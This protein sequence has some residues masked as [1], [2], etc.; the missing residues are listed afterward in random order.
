MSGLQKCRRRNILE[1]LSA[2]RRRV[3]QLESK[4]IESIIHYWILMEENK[5][6]QHQ[7]EARNLAVAS[8]GQAHDSLS[9]SERFIQVRQNF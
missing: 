2:T 3:M 1:K 5:L 4:R 8:A 9:Y 7:L 6:R